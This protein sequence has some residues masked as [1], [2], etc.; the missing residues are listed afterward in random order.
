MRILEVA[1]P[2][3]GDEFGGLISRRGDEDFGGCSS[4]GLDE[5]FGGNSSS[6]G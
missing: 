6:R 3:G 4:I 1:V 2:G 5:E